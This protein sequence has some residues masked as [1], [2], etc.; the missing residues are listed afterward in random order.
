VNAPSDSN[1]RPAL[2][3]ALFALVSVLVLVAMGYAAWIA[4]SYWDRVGV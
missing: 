3:T 4:I 1:G 2:L